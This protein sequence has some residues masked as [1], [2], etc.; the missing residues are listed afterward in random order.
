MS[1]LWVLLMQPALM[2]I[3]HGHFQYNSIMLGLTLWSVIALARKHYLVSACLFCLAVGFKHMALFYSLAYFSFLLGVAYRRDIQSGVLLVMQLGLVVLGTFGLLL[4]PF[5]YNSLDDAL[6]VM[7]RL[8]P[9]ERGLY[10]D[11]VANVWCALN[12]VVKLR[13]LFSLPVLIR[14]STIC[15]LLANLI[16]SLGLFKAR[17]VRDFLYGLTACSLAFFLF[18]FQVHEKSILIPLLPALLLFGEE[19]A[20]VDWFMNA[21]MFSMVPLLIKDKLLIAYVGLML[22]WNLLTMGASIRQTK[23]FVRPLIQVSGGDDTY[24]K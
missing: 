10:E 8:F 3:D 6:Q 17:T 18:G 24:V 16:P 4:L 7:R 21:A 11:K 19:P 20:V 5:L 2:I 23:G 9:F 12:V 22:G 1:V 15:T 13:Q 14:L